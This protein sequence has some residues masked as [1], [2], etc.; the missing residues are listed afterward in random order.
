[1]LSHFTI[2]DECEIDLLESIEK[3]LKANM[4]NGERKIYFSGEFD[5]HQSTFEK[6]SNNLE[7]GVIASNE[8]TALILLFFVRIII[9]HRKE[10]LLETVC[11]EDIEY[12]K[13]GGRTTMKTIYLQNGEKIQM[14][15]IIEK[16]SV[17]EKAYTKSFNLAEQ[18][19]VKLYY[20][21]N[22]ITIIK[23]FDEIDV[24]TF[25][26]VMSEIKDFY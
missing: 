14:E 5:S 15:K 4:D 17:K 1:M 16:L 8:T 20:G 19:T 24:W 6:A 18:F 7:I 26:R 21:N 13:K 10:L 11:Y 12:I 2:E 23:D 22:K 25:S 3:Y 9:D